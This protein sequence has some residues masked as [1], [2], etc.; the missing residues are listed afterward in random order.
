MTGPTACS[1]S[2]WPTSAWHGEPRHYLSKFH[3]KYAP[4]GAAA[5]DKQA[6]DVGLRGWP[7]L[8]QSKRTN[9]ISANPDHP[10]CAVDR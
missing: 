1:R 8:M 7:A 5:L 9:A 3:P 10:Q 4:G 2:L 6:K